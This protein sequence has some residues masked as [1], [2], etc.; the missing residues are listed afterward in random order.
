MEKLDINFPKLTRNEQTVL[1]K[2]IEQA[3]I[4]AW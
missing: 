2:I 3:K 4:P 1:K